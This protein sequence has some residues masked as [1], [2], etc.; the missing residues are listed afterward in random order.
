MNEADYIKVTN[1]TRLQVASEALRDVMPEYSGI[2]NDDYFKACSLMHEML[3]KSFN[4][5]NIV[6][7]EARLEHTE[8]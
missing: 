4:S 7:D 3:E 6:V 2:N 5:V 8:K 1:K